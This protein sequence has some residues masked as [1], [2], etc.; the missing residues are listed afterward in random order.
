MPPDVRALARHLGSLGAAVVLSSHDMVEVDALCA[1]VTVIDRGLRG[2]LGTVEH[3]RSLAPASICIL[4]TSDDA[5]ALAVGSSRSGM[6]LR[7]DS[8]GGLEVSASLA[9]LDAYVIALGCA[10]VAVRQLESRPRSLESLFLALTG[11][12][13]EPVKADPSTPGLS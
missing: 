9:A 12:D 4:R 3:L 8:E 13:R 6:T 7:A 1:V 10:G 2:V 5:V 11:Q